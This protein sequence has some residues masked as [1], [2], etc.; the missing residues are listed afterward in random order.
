MEKR[1]DIPEEKKEMASEPAAYRRYGGTAR[2][3][4]TSYQMQILEIISRV[5][6]E[7]EMAD[8]KQLLAQY[9]ADKAEDAIDKLWEEGAINDSVIEDWKNE[10]MRTPYKQS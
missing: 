4:F 8:I 6:S 1:Y 10:H 5:K 3:V 7:K 9:F 2:P